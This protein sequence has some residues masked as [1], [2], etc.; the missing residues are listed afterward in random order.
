MKQAEI[1]SRER[2]AQTQIKAHS[3]KAKAQFAADK[4]LVVLETDISRI[5]LSARSIDL[6]L[7]P[8]SWISAEAVPLI[9]SLSVQ[10][11]ALLREGRLRLV[12][13]VGTRLAP[14][15]RNTLARLLDR[16]RD[17]ASAASCGLR[18][19][20]VVRRIRRASGAEVAA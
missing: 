11:G 13:T 4:G 6:G 14:C 9:P 18:P 7:I 15:A 8:L 3:I 20:A 2:I 1:A 19:R 17:P 12:R 10:I 16:R 5:D